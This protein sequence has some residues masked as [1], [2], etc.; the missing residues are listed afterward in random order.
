MNSKNHYEP[1]SKSLPPRVH[2][3]LFLRSWPS[4]A[5]PVGLPLT[6]HR[7]TVVRTSPSCAASPRCWRTTCGSAA[8]RCGPWRATPR[9]G[10][11]PQLGW[12]DQ[13]GANEWRCL[14]HI[15]VYINILYYIYI[16]YSTYRSYIYMFSCFVFWLLYN[17]LWPRDR[18][19]GQLWMHPGPYV[20]DTL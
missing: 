9:P 19:K 12:M 13:L 14:H 1:H 3:F 18:Q 4:L 7:F 16:V 10:W 17:F 6:V 11:S 15:S 8:L 2:P 5:F 20:C